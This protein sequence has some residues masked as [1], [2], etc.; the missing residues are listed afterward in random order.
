[1]RK[2][3]LW[4]TFQNLLV[5]L[6]VLLVVFL[7]LTTRTLSII[8]DQNT[9]M[10]GSGRTALTKGKDDSQMLLIEYNHKEDIT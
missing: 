9:G 10:I 6:L 3:K 5:A 8:A 1:V 7:M 2:E 4:N